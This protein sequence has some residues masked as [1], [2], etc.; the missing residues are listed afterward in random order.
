MCP[1]QVCFFIVFITTV[2]LIQLTAKHLYESTVAR[3]ST[4]KQT[5]PLLLRLRMLDF[6][7]QLMCKSSSSVNLQT[8]ANTC[9]A[10]SISHLNSSANP[11]RL[12][13][14]KPWPRPMPHCLLKHLSSLNEI[15]ATQNLLR[16][17]QHA[18]FTEVVQYPRVGVEFFKTCSKNLVVQCPYAELSTAFSA[19]NSKIVIRCTTK[20]E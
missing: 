19:H 3:V 16:R 18:L 10:S 8:C 11:L 7:S 6:S 12:S 20:H 15:C 9:Y 5:T 4:V 17:M 13:A 14:H 1:Y 2:I